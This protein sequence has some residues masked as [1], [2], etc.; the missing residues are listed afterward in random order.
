MRRGCRPRTSE[1]PSSCII[2]LSITTT[3]AQKHD[4]TL[5]T[6]GTTCVIPRERKAQKS[7]A[8]ALTLSQQTRTSPAPVTITTRSNTL[9]LRFFASPT[10]Y[11]PRARLLP[12][13]TSQHLLRA[14]FHRPSRT[15]FSTTSTAGPALPPSPSPRHPRHTG[16]AAPEMASDEDYS[17]FLDKANEDTGAS[18]KKK[19][20]GGGVGE[21]V[22]GGFTARTV[23]A[24]EVPRA[25][26]E[27]DEVYVSEADEEFEGVSLGFAGEGKL[28]AGTSRRV[29][30]RRG[31]VRGGWVGYTGLT[32]SFPVQ[33]RSRRR[34][35]GPKIRSRRSRRRS[36]I[37]RAGTGVCW[38]R[39]ARRRGV[40][41]Q[42]C[43]CSAWVGR[44]PGWSTGSLRW[45]RTAGG[46]WASGRRRWRVELWGGLHDGG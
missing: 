5:F 44:G 30:E 38:R 8:P 17:A 20:G 18:S 16:A 27:L 19:G 26:R 7:P 43:G 39:W 32:F 13:L 37:P 10:F 15:R 11:A 33:R 24:G 46:W 29:G 35:P 42:G 3:T 25:L 28:D 23:N 45:R 6:T 41:G 22:K 1:K 4:S 31:L 21:A 2:R 40:G 14:P 12:R 34:F 9:P 36:S